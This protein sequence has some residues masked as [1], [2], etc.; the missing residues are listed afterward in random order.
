MIKSI[1]EDFTVEEKADLPLGER[2]GYR[3]Y[4]LKKSNWTTLDLIY[5]LSHS[6]SVPFKKFSYGGK[7]D[8]HGLTYQFITIKDKRDFSKRGKD[9]SLESKGFMERRMSPDL[10]K[11]NFFTITTRNLRDFESIE[12][13][14]EETKKFGFPNFFDDQRFRSFSPERGFFAEKILKKHWNGALQVFL[15]SIYPDMRRKGRQSREALLENWRDWETC[16]RLAKYPLEKRIFRHL[17][18]NPKDFEGALQLVP[19]EEISMLYSSFQSHLWNELLRRL[20]KEKVKDF[21][22]IKGSE[23]SYLF[24]KRL[25]DS[26]FFYFSKLELPTSSAKMEF[27]DD[28]SHL[29]YE[30]ILK[31]INLTKS[32]FRTEILTKVY[33][34]SFLRKAV[35]IPDD[36]QIIDKGKDEL[37]E[38][39]M[40]MTLSF[41]LPR[42]SYG[43]MLMKRLSLEP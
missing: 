14:I 39:K 9:F 10:I 25:D 34:K 17:I 26:A 4:L 32:S 23:G 37:H 36:I 21:E 16:L 8:K 15:T 40:K 29:R 43:T 18:N 28:L 31:E 35:I 33:F 2:G 5:F 22:E 12:K 20:I 27:P 38:G 41:F 30:E 1:P 11:G 19:E 24:W 13:N 6:L 3:V 7:K 42:G